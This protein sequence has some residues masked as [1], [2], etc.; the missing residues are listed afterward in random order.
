M[1]TEGGGWTVIQ[2]RKD[3]STDFYRTWKE[4]KEGFGTPSRN[5]WIGNDVIHQLTKTSPQKLRF[6]L[7]RYSGEKG[8]AEYSKFA[9]GDENSKY[10]LTVSGYSGT[11]ETQMIYLLS[12]PI[13]VIATVITS[14]V[15][16]ILKRD[17][18]RAALSLLLYVKEERKVYLNAPD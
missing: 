14:F 13:V 6:V 3:G 1:T 7:Q 2:K 10:K 9:V 18:Q 17:R 15:C 4:Y 16:L 12:P 11:I 5:Y 8:Q